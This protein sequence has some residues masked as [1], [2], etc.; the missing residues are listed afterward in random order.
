[1]KYLTLNAIR[2]L[3]VVKD[4]ESPQVL[5]KCT[6]HLFVRLSTVLL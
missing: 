4:R 1:M 2:F 3:R 6:R 5:E